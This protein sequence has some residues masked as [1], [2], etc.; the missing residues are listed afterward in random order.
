VRSKVASLLSRKEAN[1]SELSTKL[2]ALTSLCEEKQQLLERVRDSKYEDHR[3]AAE[4]APSFTTSNTT[5]SGAVA[6]N[7]SSR[8]RRA[9]SNGSSTIGRGSIDRERDRGIDV[10]LN[11][12]R[13]TISGSTLPA[14]PPW[15]GVAEPGT[16]RNNKTNKSN[17]NR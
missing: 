4:A 14:R 5:S 10:D 13:D 17:S 2:A 8:M 9:P 6:S 16:T 1:I 3:E 15:R 7:G 12:N 11:A